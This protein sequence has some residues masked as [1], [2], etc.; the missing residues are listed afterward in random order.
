MFVI[1][2]KYDKN[3]LMRDVKGK[4]LVYFSEDKAN[5]VKDRQPNGDSFYVRKA[6]PYDY[7]KRKLK[8]PA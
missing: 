1:A 2:K 3:S 5:N 6:V 4:I 7:K 8:M